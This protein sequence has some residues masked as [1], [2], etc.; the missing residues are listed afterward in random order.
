MLSC[1]VNNAEPLRTIWPPKFDVL[2]V[3][4]SAT[5]YNEAVNL[6]IESA[7]RRQ[8]AVVSHFAVHAVVSA[9][10]DDDLRKS[11]NAFEIVAPDGQPVRWALNLLYKTRLADRCY[12][13]EMTDQLCRRAAAEGVSIYL[14]GSTHEVLTKLSAN[15][16]ARYPQLMIAGVESPPFR[17]LTPAEEDEMVARI[18][19]SG[20]GI[21]FIGLGCPKQDRFAARF[22]HRLHAVQMC[23]GAAFDFHAGT[24]KSA[25][26][27]MQRYGLEWLFR[28]CQEPGRL[29]RRYLVT[30][31]VFLAKLTAQVVR[32]K[33]FRQTDSRLLKVTE[34]TVES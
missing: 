11:V 32:Q 31:T 7:R 3:G 30:N 5:N 17:A 25:P 19:D 23:V 14:Y 27:W 13:P 10:E 8:S 12:G 6:V 20:A 24:K 22:R 9:A 2:G 21:V 26:P 1:A 29:G 15:L 18:N 16:V 33:L 4:V 28:L 34:V